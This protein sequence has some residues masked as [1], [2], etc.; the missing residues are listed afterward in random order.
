MLKKKCKR[1]RSGLVYW[2]RLGVCLSLLL[3]SYGR[4][5]APT[6]LITSTR[7]TGGFHIVQLHISIN[8]L[9]QFPYARRLFFVNGHWRVLLGCSKDREWYLTGIPQRRIF[10]DPYSL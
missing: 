10:R 1:Q 2:I 5:D 6:G 3:V 4:K 9:H 8:L 7:D